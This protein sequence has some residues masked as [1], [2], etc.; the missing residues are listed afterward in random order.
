MAAPAFPT[1]ECWSTRSTATR[2]S[3]GG[4]R[5]QLHVCAWCSSGQSRRAGCL[6]ERHVVAPQLPP[7]CPPPCQGTDSLY[8]QPHHLLQTLCATAL[9]YRDKS[10]TLSWRAASGVPSPWQKSLTI[11]LMKGFFATTWKLMYLEVIWEK[12]KVRKGKESSL[13][14]RNI[15]I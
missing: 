4:D 15:N 7:C 12:Y 6:T 8:P 5:P 10:A 14:T 13:L 11:D 1:K 9:V 3:D 2:C